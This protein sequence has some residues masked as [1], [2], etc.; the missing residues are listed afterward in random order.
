MIPRIAFLGTFHPAVPTLRRLA[1]RGWIVSVVMPET[2][3]YKNR[4]LLRI[5]DEFMLPWSY[6]IG[7]IDA[8]Q[9][10]LLVA[11]NYPKLV[12]ER[13]LQSIPCL[14]THWSLLPKY[15]G[16]HPTAWAMINGDQEIGLTVHL[17]E[18]DFDTGEILIQ[19][20]VSVGPDT[21]IVELHRALSDLQAK[22]V[23]EVLES[24]IAIGHFDG[25]PQNE[26]IA[27]YVPQRVPDDGIIDWTRTSAHI[28][29]LIRAL[30]PPEY[31]GAFTHL[32]DRRLILLDATP[33]GVPSYF[34]TPGQVVRRL[35]DGSVWV[36]TGD[37]C[38]Q[39][40]RV[41]WWGDDEGISASSV[42]KRGMRLGYDPQIE[43]ATLRQEI[44]ELR[45]LL[46]AVSDHS[47]GHTSDG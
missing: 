27:T 38:L 4:E 25:A 29:A 18:R 2:G 9:P 45:R 15:R 41:Q 19:K 1:E 14:N 13:Y 37:G 3:G 11:A 26:R 36:K 31:P 6:E 44:S 10:N 24:F 8:H 47:P 42:L 43:I 7:D 33:A 34:C 22:A 30:P 39:V 35:G 12:P 32:G 28:D 16:V 21:Q 20:R 23:E 5:A 40:Q 17:M 46:S